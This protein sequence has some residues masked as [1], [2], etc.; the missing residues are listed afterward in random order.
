MSSPAFGLR[1]RGPYI[2]DENMR[3]ISIILLVYMLL[4]IATV[5]GVNIA[6][7]SLREDTTELQAAIDAE[8]NLRLEALE[9]DMRI[10]KTDVHILQYGV[11]DEEIDN[12]R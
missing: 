8:Q 12:S 7:I 1:G 3:K 11:T 6:E 10:L 5:I 9:K 2:E 4:A